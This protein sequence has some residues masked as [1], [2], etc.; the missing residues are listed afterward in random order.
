EALPETADISDD[1]YLSAA[2]I[3]GDQWAGDLSFI[4][5]RLEIP[6]AEYQMEMLANH[7]DFAR[8][9]VLGHSTGGGAAIQFC[10]TDARCQAALGMDPYMDP[11]SKQVQ[12]Q[13]FNQPYLAMFSESWAI[14]PNRNNDIFKLFFNNVKEDRF[15]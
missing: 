4:V 2:Q 8:I 1:E 5:D 3:L 6:G 11:V 15:H 12:T 9:G 10:A 7:I 13:D 14:E